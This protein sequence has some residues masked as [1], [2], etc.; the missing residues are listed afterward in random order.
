M[1]QT[2]RS[3]AGKIRKEWADHLG[4]DEEELASLLS[5]LSIRSGREGL[6]DLEKHQ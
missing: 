2:P 3:A 6:D 1:T 5:H 4:V